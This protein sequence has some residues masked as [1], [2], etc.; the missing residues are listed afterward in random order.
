M[1]VVDRDVR[2]TSKSDLRVDPVVM[3]QTRGSPVALGNSATTMAELVSAIAEAG[4]DMAAILQNNCAK[5][6]SSAKESI[7]SRHSAATETHSSHRSASG[8][9]PP[10]R[11][12]G[13]TIPL[14]RARSVPSSPWRAASE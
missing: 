7:E 6:T 9:P 5:A 3:P 4:A 12:R 14:E 8:D 2:G 10:E 11:S 1:D 13:G